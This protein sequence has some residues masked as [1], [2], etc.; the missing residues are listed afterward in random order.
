[1]PV[2]PKKL[3]EEKE[4]EISETYGQMR[5]RSFRFLFLNVLIVLAVFSLLFFLKTSSPE[6]YSN[7]V[8]NLQL[9]VELKKIEYISPEKIGAKVYLVNTKKTEKN[10]TLSDFYL[11]I[12]SESYTVYEFSF[13]TIVESSVESLGRKLVYNLENEVSLLNLK[14]DTYTLYVRCKINGREVETT[15][16]FTYKEEIS[17]MIISEPFYLVDEEIT[18]GVAIINK[19]ATR[20]TFDVQKIEWIFGKEHISENINEQ[21]TLL[22]GESYVF[23]SAHKFKIENIGQQEVSALLYLTDG[24]IKE[25]RGIIPVSKEFENS[26]SNL[27]FSLETEDVV[28]V[29]KE[30]KINL[31]I[32]NKSNE[33]RFLKIDKIQIS[34]PEAGYDFEINNRRIFLAP[35]S[36]SFV[37]KFER[38][39]FAQPG[40][41]KI[42]VQTSLGKSVIKREMTI[43]VGK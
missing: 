9:V 7:I 11:K 10:F 5:K 29:N 13:P 22:S 38:L 21:V 27:D 43:A 15:R 33:N 28:V 30:P 18:P 3:R 34:I 24:G 42:L 32:V 4:N 17:Y 26:L 8:E 12:Y 39:N 14:P 35:L 31:Y 6:T 2:D 37:T 41:Y 1:M 20:K 23:R 36:R 40:V 25:V 19:T 16:T